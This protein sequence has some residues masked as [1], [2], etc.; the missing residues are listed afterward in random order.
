MN[1]QSK[2]WSYACIFALILGRTFIFTPFRFTLKYLPFLCHTISPWAR[3]AHD[4]KRFRGH[5]P[6]P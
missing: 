3:T 6:A 1:E 5:T 4:R 2:I